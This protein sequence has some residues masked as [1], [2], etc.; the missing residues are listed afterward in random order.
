[1]LT[2]PGLALVVA[3]A[4]CAS[5]YSPSSCDALDPELYTETY[6]PFESVNRTIY[7]LNLRMD[8]AVY[9]PLARSYR[10][11]TP[12]PVEASVSSFYRNLKEPRNLVSSAFA[13]KFEVAAQSGLRFSINTT[14]GLFGIFDVADYMGVSYKDHDFGH[15]FGAWSIG[16]GPYVVYPF[17]GP[18]NL[19]ATVGSVVNSRHTYVEKHIENSEHQMA[20][21]VGSIVDTRARLLPFTDLAAE[22]ADPYL[23]VRESYRQSRLDVI[24]N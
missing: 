3:L 21:Q 17:A 20:V 8:K 4:G 15:M 14:L 13:G 16:D 24:C 11:V 9:E 1:M 19:T 6:D 12:D 18:S 7:R 2:I 10:N 23:F 5:T 22:Q